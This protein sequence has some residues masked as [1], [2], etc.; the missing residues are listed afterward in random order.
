MQLRVL[1]ADDHPVYLD[2]IASA[3][4]AAH[5][6]HLIATCVDGTE[7]LDRIREL[8]PD[9]AVLDA[10]MPGLTAHDVLVAIGDSK[11]TR[12]LVLSAY[13]DG[14]D[15]YALL[16]AGAAGFVSKDLS[17]TRICDAVRAVAQGRAVLGDEAQTK[18]TAE[19]LNRRN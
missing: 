16:E 7:A 11:P 18:V 19:I 10:R 17:R 4:S 3:I 5:D 6:L 8:R 13:T 1:V 15:I 14:A 12:V 9:V 2:G